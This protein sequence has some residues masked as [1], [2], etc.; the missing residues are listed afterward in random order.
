MAIFRTTAT[1]FKSPVNRKSLFPYLLLAPGLLYLAVFFLAPIA[2]LG[3]MSTKSKNS[4][5]VTYSQ[6]FRFQ[7]YI[8]A[9]LQ[10]KE[11][12]TRS[13]L[14]GLLATILALAIAYPLAYGIAFKAGRFK[15]VLL[16][17]IVAPFF[18]SFLLRKRKGRS[19][20]PW[21]FFALPR[22]NLNLR[23]IENHFFLT[24]Y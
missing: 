4:D 5:G 22:L 21:P 10:S 17:L 14:Y 8:D 15:N 11:Q 1:K 12:F 9:F 7:N 13:F 24:C 2:T 20:N 23:Q 16:V 18:T 3:Q 19:L 6:V